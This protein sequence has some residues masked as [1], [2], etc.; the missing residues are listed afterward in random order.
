[1]QLLIAVH[2]WSRKPITHTQTVTMSS[3]GV[4]AEKIESDSA[5]CVCIMSVALIQ[6]G[7]V[8]PAAVTLVLVVSGCAVRVC[9]GRAW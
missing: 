7:V 1:V 5:C 8:E 9:S 2:V 3:R 4:S 6:Q